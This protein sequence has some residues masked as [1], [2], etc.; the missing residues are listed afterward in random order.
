MKQTFNYL[1]RWSGDKADNWRQIVELP[2]INTQELE[3]ALNIHP[4][5]VGDITCLQDN[6]WFLSDP[7][8]IDGLAAY[9]EFV[10]RSRGEFS[11][12]DNAYVTFNTGW[13]SDRSARYL[14]SGRPVLVQ[15]TGVESHIPTG[16]GLITFS[17]MEEAAAAIDTINRDYVA[18]C[19][20]ARKLA[21]EYFDSDKVLSK[22]L[23]QIGL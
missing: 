12:A 10:A 4:G 22:M 21:E 20:A 13:F 16:K 18:H 2:R 17:T 14:A 6:G 11:V 3:I 5:Y 9:I 8:Q 7:G 1:G 19:S 23:S 15:S